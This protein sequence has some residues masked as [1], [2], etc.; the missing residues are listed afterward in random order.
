MLA[1]IVSEYVGAKGFAEITPF[2][3]GLACGAVAATAARTHGHGR[4]DQVVRLIGG[5]AAVLGTAF[6]FKLVPGGQ[7]PF[8]PA[9]TVL[10]PYVSALA[11]AIV[12][13]AFR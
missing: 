9:G 4:L 12:S 1:P 8:G 10:P 2:L 11:G 13:R 5:C 3:L 6:A 7:D